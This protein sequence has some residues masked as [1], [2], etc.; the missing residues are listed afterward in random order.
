MGIVSQRTGPLW[1]IA[2]KDG[3]TYI[4]VE[5]TAD[6]DTIAGYAGGTS[7]FSITPTDTL[8]STKVS[9]GAVD[10]MTVNGS[11][12]TAKLAIH[13]E[14]DGA[15]SELELHRHNADAT[16]GAIMYGARSRGT[17]AS[18]SIVSSGD[19]L[20]SFGAAGH[21]GTDYALSS[22]VDFEV[23][24]TPGNNDMP[25]RIL[26]KTS[27]D[28]TQTPV[29]KIRVSSNSVVVNNGLE[30]YD[31][32][33]NGNNDS[34]V[35]K[36]DAGNDGTVMG[37]TSSTF[38]RSGSTINSKFLSIKPDAANWNAGAQAIFT[39]QALRAADFSLIKARGTEA[40]PSAVGAS[41]VISNVRFEGHDGTDFEVSAL[42][43]S[44]VDGTVSAG[45]IPGR[46]DLGVANTAG[47]VNSMI[48]LRSSGYVGFNG[49]ATP[50]SGVDLAGSMGWTRRATAV[51]T[52]TAA[53]DVIIATTST[54]SARTHTIRT[55]DTVGRRIYIFTDEGGN[56][57]T[58][59]ITIATEGSE[60]IN[61]AATYVI[62]TNY[63]SVRL[64]SNG[65]NWFT[66]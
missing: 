39:S 13:E 6:S 10:Q 44:S 51:D 63:G 29:E 8:F 41:D 66:F 62:N 57:G 37:G 26:F 23:D 64:Y 2:D 34:N 20:M 19:K 30:D 1:Y 58:N 38:V 18:P 55:A 21:D 4:S 43:S 9:I 46:L 53:T 65:T 33:V 59:N 25:G 45:V 35:L 11:A 48:S 28:G 32:I 12:I 27:V 5:A 36:I 42:I 22:R 3:D 24:G 61:G 47:T 17:E 16:A 31:F 60:L 14:S 49:R 52:N 56:A 15:N 40:S 7:V 50:L 54:A